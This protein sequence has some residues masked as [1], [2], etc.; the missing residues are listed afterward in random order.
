VFRQYLPQHNSVLYAGK[1]IFCGR[2]PELPALTRSGM[3]RIQA[4]VDLLSVKPESL[5]LQGEIYHA[6]N[7]YDHAS[8]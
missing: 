7:S 6:E 8:G 4:A 5:T 3:T 1:I 2:L